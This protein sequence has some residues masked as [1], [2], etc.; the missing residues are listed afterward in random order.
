MNNFKF[1]LLFDGARTRGSCERDIHGIHSAI[2]VWKINATPLGIF[3]TILKV[4]S[5]NF[6]IILVYFPSVRMDTK[7]TWGVANICTVN[8][9]RKQGL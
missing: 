1:L 3:V 6:F 8:W 4:R 2:K 7:T 5:I 9:E